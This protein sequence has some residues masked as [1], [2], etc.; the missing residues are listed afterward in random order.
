MFRTES[1]QFDFED[2]VRAREVYCLQAAR[3]PNV[4]IFDDISTCTL[5]SG[6]VLLCFRQF[7][8]IDIL[9]VVCCGTRY[10][11]ENWIMQLLLFVFGHTNQKKT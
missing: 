10:S 5:N 4:R 1:E 6:V 11:E 2:R 9:V 8:R 3:T 7:F